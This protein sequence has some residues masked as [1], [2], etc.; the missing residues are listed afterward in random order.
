L[1]AFFSTW[2]GLKVSTRRARILVP[3]HEV[4]ETRDLDLF[5]LFQGFFDRVENG[6]HDL[7]GLFLRESADLLV[8]RFDDVR[9]GHDAYVGHK[10]L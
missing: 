1:S 6:L 2:L 10:S 8:D 7:G 4:P 9:L 5:A 3:N